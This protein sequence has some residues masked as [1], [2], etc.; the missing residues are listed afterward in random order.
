[1]EES[2]EEMETTEE[3]DWVVAVI[4][5]LWGFRC[6]LWLLVETEAETSVWV[7]LLSQEAARWG[8]CWG[9]CGA[10]SSASWESAEK[11]EAACPREGTPVS[12]ALSN[13]DCVGG[14]LGRKAFADCCVSSSSSLEPSEEE[15]KAF[16]LVWLLRCRMEAVG[17]AGNWDVDDKMWV[18]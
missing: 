5:T 8:G 6:F 9:G 2:A 14:A 1:M 16:S 12:K 18:E 4:F 11:K 17:L 3:E 15:L 7:S 13:S 10:V